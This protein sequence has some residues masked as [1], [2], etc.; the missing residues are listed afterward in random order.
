MIEISATIMRGYL[1]HRD[2]A[3]NSIELE[4]F[5]SSQYTQNT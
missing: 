2:V 3:K 5:F 4:C 1:L